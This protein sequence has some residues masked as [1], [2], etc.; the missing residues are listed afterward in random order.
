MERCV[1]TVVRGIRT[2][3]IKEGDN[4]C[5]IVVNSLL[6]ASKNENFSF[7]DRDIVAVTEA[8]VSIADGAYVSIDEIALD[9]ENK[10]PSKDIGIIFPILSRNRFSMILKSIARGV[11]KITIQLSYPSDEVGNH[12]FSEDLL[13]KYNINPYSNTLSLEEYNKYFG[14]ITHTFTGVNYVNFYKEICEKENCEVDFVFSN[15]PKTILNYTKDVLVCDIHTRNK[16]KEILIN[17]GGNN[18][19]G[20][21]NIMQESINGSRYNEKYGLLGSNKSTEERLKLFPTSG[22]KLVNDIQE[23]LKEKTG[24]NIE[25]MVYGDGAFKDPVGKI[26]ELAD[27]VVSPFYTNG[28]EGTPNEIKLKYISDNKYNNLRGEELSNAIKNEI[29][30]KEEDLK[31]KNTS[32]GTTPRRLTDLIGSLCDLTSGSGDKGT[33]VVFIQGYFDNYAS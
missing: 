31:G 30:N 7:N 24:K 28:L 6:K 17:N 14:N 4:L 19:Y 21:D 25:V 15:D 13:E 26:W 1:G 32:L 22:E 9:I 3:I 29:K 23:K 2:P 12:L 5:D 18:I 20:L 16:T 11:N 8:V 27:P 33:P 10:F